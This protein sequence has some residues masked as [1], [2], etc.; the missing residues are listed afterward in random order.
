MIKKKFGIIGKP[1]SHSLSP[2]LHNFWFKKYKISGSYSLIEIEKNEIEGVIKKMRNN[3]LHGLNV[4]VPYKQAVIPFLDLIVDEAKKT[5]SVNTISLN[6]EG[7]IV[8]NNTDVYGLEQGFINKI[9]SQK[10]DK[11]KVLILGAGGVAPSVIYALSEKGIKQIFISN[12]TM[13]KAENIKKIFPFIKIIKWENIEIE[14]ENMNIIV[15]A[16]SLGLKNGNDFAQEFKAIKS[17]LVYYDVVYNPEETTMAKKLKNKG[18][19]IFNGLEMFIYQGQKSFSL[20]NKISPELNEEL[21]KILTSK[22]K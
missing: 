5:M 13:E 14:A 6:K 11:D 18:A 10:L 1:L 4:T 17:N 3:E 16:T 12:R 19:K 9:N 21:K 8:G 22:L 20:W 15:N 7:K 2:E